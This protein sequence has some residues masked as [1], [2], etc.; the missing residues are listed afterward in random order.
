[1]G[2]SVQLHQQA[3]VEGADRQEQAAMAGKDHDVFSV[4]GLSA[5]P[6]VV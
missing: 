5:Q 6:V 1:M 2:L 3:A 4:S